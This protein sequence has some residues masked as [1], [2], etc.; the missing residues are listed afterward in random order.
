MGPRKHRPDLQIRIF[1]PNRIRLGFAGLLVTAATL[2]GFRVVE[3]ALVW[4]SFG[5][6]T[7]S[8]SVSCISVLG[9]SRGRNLDGILDISLLIR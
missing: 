4:S 2:P 7:V 5:S 8:G 6:S 3:E 9:P 1:S